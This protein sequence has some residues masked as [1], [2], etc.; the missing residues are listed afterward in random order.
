MSNVSESPVTQLVDRSLC[1]TIRKQRRR[2]SNERADLSMSCGDNSLRLE[3]ELVVAP[4]HRADFTHSHPASQCDSLSW[5][6]DLREVIQAWP[7][8]SDSVRSTI[9]LLAASA[10]LSSLRTAL[11]VV[12]KSK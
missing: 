5:S 4:G 10:K 3:Q 12:L 1:A 9:C 8:L 11:P 7:T 2:E 6:A